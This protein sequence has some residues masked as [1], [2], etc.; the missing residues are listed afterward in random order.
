MPK[1]RANLPLLSNKM[2]LTDSGLETTLIFHEGIELPFFAAFALLK[3]E[4]GVRKLRRY[5]ASHAAIAEAYGAGF[6]RES[7]TWRANA[8]WGAKLGYSAAALAA[9]NRRAIDLMV[10]LREGCESA[11]SPMV[12]SGCV[13]PRG[14]GY[15]PGRVMSADEAQAYHA[16]QIE[17]F[18]ATE[19]DLVTAITMTNVVAIETGGLRR[20]EWFGPCLKT[21]LT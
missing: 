2:F 7:P 4:E 6:I 10:D 19:A 12:I 21:P 17:V 14:D 20:G 3:T 15:D 16:A 5:Y 1:Y 9:I 18:A 13:G 8:E 11:R